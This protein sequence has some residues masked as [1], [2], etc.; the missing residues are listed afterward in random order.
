MATRLASGLSDL[1][2]DGY[3][4]DNCF[5]DNV[6]G[7]ATGPPD[8]QTTYACSARPFTGTPFDPVIDEVA[9]ALVYDPN[10]TQIEPPEPNRPR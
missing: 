1:A 4:E 10:R 3:G 5:D 6:I 2:W 8:I 9:A 7:G